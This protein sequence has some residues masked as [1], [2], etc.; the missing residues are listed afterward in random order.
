MKITADNVSREMM[1]LAMESVADTAIIPMQD[2]LGLGGECRMNRPA[3][4]NGNWVWRLKASDVTSDTTS[5]LKDMTQNT[6][7]AV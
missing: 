7:R 4:A 1:R 6:N 2:V 5:F 3:Q